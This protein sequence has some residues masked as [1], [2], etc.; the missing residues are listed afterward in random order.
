MHDGSLKQFISLSS[1]GHH[2]GIIMMNLV[3]MPAMI[4]FSFVA[5]YGASLPYQH[6]CDSNLPYPS[7][8]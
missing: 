3:T 6:A 5:K 2:Y 8:G 4:E 7:S 1:H